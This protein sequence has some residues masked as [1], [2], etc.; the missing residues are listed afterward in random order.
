MTHR[1]FLNNLSNVD[2]AD[3][4]AED[5]IF[6]MACVESSKHVNCPYPVGS[7]KCKQCIKEFLDSEFEEPESV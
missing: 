6:N 2:L 7:H 3:I 1:D 4:I 5:G